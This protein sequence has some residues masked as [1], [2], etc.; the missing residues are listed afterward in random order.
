MNCMSS[1]I[2]LLFACSLTLC[3]TTIYFEKIYPG[4]PMIHRPRY[5]AA[6]ILPPASRP[7][8]CLQYM[9]W[10]H[11]AS[12]SDKYSSLH[13]IFYLRARKYAELDELKGFGECM[14]TLAHCQTWLL[15]TTYEFRMML[16]PRA[17]LSA[18]Q[19]ARL[20]AMLGLNRLDGQGLDVKQTL[21]PPKDWT[22]EEERRRVLWLTFCVDRY[23]SVGTGWPVTLDERDVSCSIV[24][25]S[26]SEEH[27]C[28]TEL[29]RFPRNFL[30]LRSLSFR[31]SPSNL[32]VLQML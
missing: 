20:A 19:A 23:A 1:V 7:P 25:A 5:L 2:V 6:T 4:M 15:I 26:L 18:G 30:P 14:V 22:E 28:L 13:N 3:S 11:A 32:C 9:I 16:F 21:S 17:W 29:N 27:L 8:I 12:V 10:C 31:T 24:Y